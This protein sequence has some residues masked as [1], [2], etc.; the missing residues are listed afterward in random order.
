LKGSHQLGI[1]TKT[2]AG[3]NGYFNWR[4]LGCERGLPAARLSDLPVWLP[5]EWKRRQA[6]RPDSPFPT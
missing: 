6:A 3:V 5:D 4:Q 2:R 1:Y